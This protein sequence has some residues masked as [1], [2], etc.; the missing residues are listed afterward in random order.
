MPIIELEYLDQIAEV[1]ELV[2]QG[3]LQVKSIRISYTSRWYK[4][5]EVRVMK[6]EVGHHFPDIPITVEDTHDDEALA[7]TLDVEWTK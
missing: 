5:D 7:V 1:H 4:D 6:S 2:S 3:R